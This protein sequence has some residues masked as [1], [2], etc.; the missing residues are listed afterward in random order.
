MRKRQILIALIALTLV[1][2]SAPRLP[3]IEKS[4][5]LE[6]GDPAR[7]DKKADLVLDAITDTRTGELLSPAEVAERLADKRL[8]LVGESHTDIN[9]H[10]AQLR[11]IQELNKAGRK[12]LLGLEMF[13]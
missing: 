5:T 1:L 6:I 4:L 13:P 9:F 3:A 2:T 10:R 8:V 7:K 11:I 12:V